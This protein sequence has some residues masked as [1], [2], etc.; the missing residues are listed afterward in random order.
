VNQ[1]GEFCLRFLNCERTH[2]IYHLV[3]C[4]PISPLHFEPILSAG[5]LDRYEVDIQVAIDL[6]A[7]CR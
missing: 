4:L 5:S 2:Q 3:I 7:S 6:P 1:L